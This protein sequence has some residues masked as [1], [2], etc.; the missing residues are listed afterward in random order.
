MF[1]DFVSHSVYE[2]KLTP[3]RCV[4]S[5]KASTELGADEC[6]AVFCAVRSGTEAVSQ[7]QSSCATRIRRF[8]FSVLASRLHD[9]FAFDNGNDAV[10]CRNSDFFVHSVRPE[11]LH[12]IH[13]GGRAQSEMHTLIGA[14]SV[15]A[16][17]EDIR[18]LTDRPRSDDTFAPIASRGLFG[19]PTNF[20]VSQ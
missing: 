4:A 14:G 2:I 18:A 11:Y 8:S 15:T 12:L 9:S 1:R 17:A 19:P 13:F 3:S 6:S 5:T 7:K 16:S 20:S 10:D